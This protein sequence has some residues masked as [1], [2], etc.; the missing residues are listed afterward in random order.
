MPEHRAGIS[1][2]KA[3]VHRLVDQESKRELELLKMF[4]EAAVD[5]TAEDREERESLLAGAA[6]AEELP[7]GGCTATT[8]DMLPVA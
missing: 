1:R 5:V 2:T 6:L 4:N 8:P 7:G 3:V